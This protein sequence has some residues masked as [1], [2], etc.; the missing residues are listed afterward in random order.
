MLTAAGDK[1]PVFGENKLL[2]VEFILRLIKMKHPDIAKSFDEHKIPQ[3][4]LSIMQT[5]YTHTIL[6]LQIF[7]IFKESFKSEQEDMI[8][9]VCNKII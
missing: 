9:T 4:L 1:R 8:K 6:H 5:Y 7:E 3:I 2:V